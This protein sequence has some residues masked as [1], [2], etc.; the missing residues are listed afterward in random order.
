MQQRYVGNSGLRVSA[1][2]LGTRSWGGETDEQNAS[3]LLRTFLDAVP[4]A[5]EKMIAA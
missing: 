4:L 5:Q 2:S 3:E 1:L